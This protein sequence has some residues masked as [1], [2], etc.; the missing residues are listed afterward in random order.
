MSQKKLS[1]AKLEKL[2]KDTF[3][4]FL[5]ET[6]LENGLVPD[7]TKQDLPCSIT[8]VEL[9]LSCYPV[10]VENKFIKREEAVGRVL[11][12]LRFFGI[13]HKGKT[14]MRPA[15]KVFSTIL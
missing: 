2:Q 12:T 7:S 3:S 13:A 4:Y 10:A 9:A 15:T 5:N 1:K 8:A 11:A 6:N 14:R